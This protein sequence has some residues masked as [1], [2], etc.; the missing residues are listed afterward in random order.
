LKTIR[1][2]GEMAELFAPEYKLDVNSPA[3]GLRALC[4]V[5][6]GFKEYLTAHAESFF[7]VWVGETPV[8]EHNICWPASDREVIK[9]APA[10]AGSS[11]LGKLIVGALMIAAVVYSGGAA[12]SIFGTTLFGS[13]TV[14]S[15]VTSLGVSL[16]LGGIGQMLAPSPNTPAALPQS[17]SFS[18]ALNNTRQGNPVPVCYGELIVGSQVIST[19]ISVQASFSAPAASPVNLIC[20]GGNAG[21]VNLLAKSSSPSGGGLTVTKVTVAGTD[22]AVPLSASNP[23]GSTG[24]LTIASNGDVVFTPSGGW[25]GTISGMVF[26][27]SDGRQT[28]TSQLSITA[29]QL[30]N[31]STNFPGG[32]AGS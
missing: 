23:L 18:G 2:Y 5:V 29:S 9:I 3:E 27:V 8:D 1:L 11:G 13:I 14:G 31:G 16:I 28:A 19:G 7:S 32:D 21:T 15:I 26:T 30:E 22:Y 12:A 25:V 24:V 4:V 17:Y 20:Y 6:Q 10:I